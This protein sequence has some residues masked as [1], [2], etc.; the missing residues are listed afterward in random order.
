M[1]PLKWTQ[2]IVFYSSF[3]AGCNP[4]LEGVRYMKNY[5]G[6]FEWKKRVKTAKAKLPRG[7]PWKDLSS[8]PNKELKEEW[9]LAA[10]DIRLLRAWEAWETRKIVANRRGSIASE[11]TRIKMR[12]SQTARRK[13]E[14]LE[15][16]RHV[17]VRVSSED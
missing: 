6:W 15:R 11:E 8:L 7:V 16:W 1:S 10:E 3:F 4:V 17:R 9:S 13:R 12:R 5:G 2:C 14:R